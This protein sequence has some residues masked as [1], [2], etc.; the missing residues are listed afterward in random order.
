MARSCRSIYDVAGCVNRAFQLS[1]TPRN[2]AN[3]F[4]ATEIYPYDPNVLTEFDF[5]NSLSTYREAPSPNDENA[6]T[7][8]QASNNMEGTPNSN[9]INTAADLQINET[10]QT[11]IYPNSSNSSPGTGGSLKSLLS[12]P[13]RT[14]SN[15]TERKSQPGRSFVPTDTPE[16]LLLEEKAKRKFPKAAKRKALFSDPHASAEEDVDDVLPL[17]PAKKKYKKKTNCDST[18]N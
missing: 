11:P 3:G 9:G 15:K 7:S 13:K 2:I 12:L 6:S 10:D 14:N 4:K 8:A 18:R 16:K 5:A 17:P 1:F